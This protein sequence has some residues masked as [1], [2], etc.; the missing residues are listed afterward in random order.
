ME[1]TP[2][3]HTS[4]SVWFAVHTRHQHEKAPAALLARKGFEVFLPLYAAAHRWKDRV[5]V[6]SLPLFTCYVFLKG[7]LSRRLDV[8][9]TPGV[10]AIVGHAGKAAFIP[11]SEIEALQRVVAS[12]R[13][14]EPHPFL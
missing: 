14:I 8:A 9:M 5:K 4:Q 6:L 12:G 13:P 7:D 11:A 3:S 2:D 1:L 10:H